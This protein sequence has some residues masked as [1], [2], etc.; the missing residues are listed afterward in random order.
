MVMEVD[1]SAEFRQLQC[2]VTYIQP[3]T[4]RLVK[5][6][7]VTLIKSLNSNVVV[8]TVE[9]PHLLLQTKPLQVWE[10]ITDTVTK[11]IPAT[12]STEAGR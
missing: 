8:K 6:G 4:D 7:Q 5:R 10:C 2:Q 9:G 1:V 3:S 11:K 12:V